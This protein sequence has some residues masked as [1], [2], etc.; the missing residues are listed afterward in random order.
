VLDP[1][2][3]QEALLVVL[4]LAMVVTVMAVPVAVLPS[5]KSIKILNS[6]KMIASVLIDRL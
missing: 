3:F 1:A 6:L 2:V 5:K 4:L